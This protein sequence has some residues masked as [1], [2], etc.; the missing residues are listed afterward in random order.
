MLFEIKGENNAAIIEAL[1]VFNKEAELEYRTAIQKAKTI[2]KM[3]GQ[4]DIPLPQEF[5]MLYWEQ[6]GYVY[7]RLPFSTPRVI[8]IFRKHKVMAKNMES[9]LKERGL[10]CKV[11]YKNEQDEE[12]ICSRMT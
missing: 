9:F 6:D 12:L 8:K 1:I 10:K 4:G 7:V 3:M 5:I 11:E 2:T